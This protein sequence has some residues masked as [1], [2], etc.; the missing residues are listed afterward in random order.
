MRCWNQGFD[1]LD[2]LR[3]HRLGGRWH[4]DRCPAA[5]RVATAPARRLRRGRWWCRGRRPM[6]R[7]PGVRWPGPEVSCKGHGVS[8]WRRPERPG[9]P[10]RGGRCFSAARCRPRRRYSSILWMV[11]LGGPSSITCGQIWAMNRP[12]LVPPVV[13]SWVSM[14]V[15]LRMA[16]RTASTRVPGGVRKGRPLVFQARS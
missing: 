6:A 3:R 10:A 13:D 5:S 11:A 16:A 2:L 14:P 12:S 4:P 7:P 1:G 9:F 15:S 8:R